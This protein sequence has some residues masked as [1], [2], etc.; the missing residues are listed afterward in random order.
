M[1][2]REIVLLQRMYKVS[3]GN[4]LNRKSTI[5]KLISSSMTNKGRNQQVIKNVEEPVV[6][7]SEAR[8]TMGAR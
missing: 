7:K 5:N 8:L 6:P 2:T 3:K 4:A 1:K